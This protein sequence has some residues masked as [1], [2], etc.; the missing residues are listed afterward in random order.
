MSQGYHDLTMQLREDDGVMCWFEICPGRTIYYK[1][2]RLSNTYPM[3]FSDNLGYEFQYSEQMTV[4][5][6]N[7]GGT[8]LSPIS[9]VALRFKRDYLTL[10]DLLIFAGEPI[11]VG[12]RVRQQLP[13]QKGIC[14]SRGMSTFFQGIDYRIDADLAVFSLV[15]GVPKRNSY[16]ESAEYVEWRGFGQRPFSP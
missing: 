15:L 6:S 11:S 10:G 16:C 5:I 7:D 4:Q 12:S 13:W 2:K 3:I 8:E 9:V 1:A 14:F